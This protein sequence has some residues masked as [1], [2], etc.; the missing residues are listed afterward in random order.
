MSEKIKPEMF[1]LGYCAE[2]A[3]AL[4]DETDW[5]LRVFMEV[6]DDE[7]G[8]ESAGLVHAGCLAPNGQ[9]ADVRGLRDIDAVRA[10]CLLSPAE[11]GGIKELVLRPYT[12]NDVEG[13]FCLD[14]TVLG[15]AREY[16]EANKHLSQSPKTAELEG[17]A[18]AETQVLRKRAKS[19]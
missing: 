4:H 13:E 2:F 19:K 6:E 11:Y 14:P 18:K 17:S 5:P 12:R 10:N 15:M 3:I 1:T 16:V 9:F 8:E 7:W